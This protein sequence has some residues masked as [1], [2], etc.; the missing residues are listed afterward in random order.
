VGGGGQVREQQ[1]DEQNDAQVD[2]AWPSEP[3]RGSVPQH[4]PNPVA[5]L[6]EHPI[7][8]TLRDKTYHIV[9]DLT[10]QSREFR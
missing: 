2:V 9:F 3:M 7:F 4:Y 8:D 6:I 1:R 5:K 10:K